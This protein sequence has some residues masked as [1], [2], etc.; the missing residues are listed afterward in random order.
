VTLGLAVACKPAPA[1]VERDIAPVIVDAAPL[2]SS[3]A[4]SSSPLEPARTLSVTRAQPYT[5]PDASAS[6]PDYAAWVQARHANARASR[7]ELVRIPLHRHGP[8]W[9]CTCPLHYVGVTENADDST[10]FI[11]PSFESPATGFD[12]HG[13]PETRIVE[14]YFTGHETKAPGDA[15]TVYTLR[16][17]RVLRD[18]APRSAKD[19]SD[20]DQLATVLATG[21]EA[22]LELPAPDA[23]IFLLMDASFPMSAAGSFDAAR[24]RAGSFVEHYPGAEVVDSRTVPGLFCCNYVVVL[25]RFASQAEAEAEAKKAKAV[26]ALATVRK[27]W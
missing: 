9:G 16:G 2:A 23:R 22:A 8:G 17:F 14:G 19:P 25:D 21:S 26:G 13:Q 12:P 15:K 7:P 24:K 3:A 20:E 4:P 18:R 10:P 6:A 27:G 1:S 5:T 11:E